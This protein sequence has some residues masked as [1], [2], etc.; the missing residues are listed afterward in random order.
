MD[1]LKAT[2][3]QGQLWHGEGPYYGPG[4][5][6]SY[7]H[8]PDV[9]LIETAVGPAIAWEPR[10]H[11]DPDSPHVFAEGSIRTDAAGML[12]AFLAL[13]SRGEQGV[14]SFAGRYGVL[15]LCE[16]GLA[17]GHSIW[18]KTPAETRRCEPQRVEPVANW[19]ALV[20]KFRTVA[21]LAIDLHRGGKGKA[22]DWE[23]LDRT[24]YPGPV[25]ARGWRST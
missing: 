23:D 25:T 8:V 3:Q 9:H 11:P 24:V 20:Q 13:P 2:L 17:N 4:G 6:A 1:R 7:W 18:G 22:A 15:G 16:H 21:T 19:L 10:Y 12:G 5:E 14:L